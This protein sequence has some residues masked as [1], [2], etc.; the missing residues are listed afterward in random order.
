MPEKSLI[1][2]VLLP[3]LKFVRSE[4]V[5]RFFCE[6]VSEFEVCHRCATPS[7]SVYDHRWVSLKDAPLRQALPILVVLKRRFMCGPCK[8]P[9][10]E[11]IP[12]VLP[13]KRT[14]QR[15][16]AALLE[17]SEKFHSMKLVREE[18][19]ASSDFVYRARYEQL[20][21]KESKRMYNGWPDKIGLD[22]HS[23]GKDPLWRRTRF[24]TLLVNQKRGR[25]MEVIKGKTTSDVA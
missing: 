10:T 9:F 16:K 1:S 8:K 4:G 3:E 15:F 25:L 14:T 23:V 24:V 5:S 11:P 17:A 20:K 7:H 12:G 6:K 2:F 13:G 21:L 18:F 22:E 19:N